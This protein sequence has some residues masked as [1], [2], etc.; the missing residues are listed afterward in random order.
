MHP[1][2]YA[3]VLAA[4]NVTEFRKF[5]KA[6]ML[7]L[8]NGAPSMAALQILLESHVGRRRRVA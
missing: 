4:M 5:R 2:D 3:E 8:R 7:L 1:T 6:Y